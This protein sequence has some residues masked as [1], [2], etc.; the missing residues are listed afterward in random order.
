M[1]LSSTTSA[2]ALNKHRQFKSASTTST[3]DQCPSRSVIGL[4]FA[5]DS[6][7]QH[8]FHAQQQGSSSHSTSGH[9]K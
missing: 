5:F 2:I 9:T 8:P 3:I 1:Q 4:F 7:Q 6:G